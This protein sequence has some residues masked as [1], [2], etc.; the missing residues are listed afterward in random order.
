MKN[1]L[2]L[3]ESRLHYRLFLSKALLLLL[4]VSGG[5]FLTSCNSPAKRKYLVTQVT[6]VPPHHKLVGNG[7][8][9]EWYVEQPAMYTVRYKRIRPRGKGREYTVRVLPSRFRLQAGDT[10]TY[11][12]ERQVWNSAAMEDRH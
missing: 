4:I 2:R 8:G 11:E 1:T 6:L 10:L 3:T 12:Q 5:K 7:W 9:G